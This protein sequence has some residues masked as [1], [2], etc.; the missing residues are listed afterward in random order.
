[1]K[2]RSPSFYVPYK[3]GIDEGSAE[4]C[5]GRCSENETIRFIKGYE[6]KRHYLL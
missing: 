5:K 3:H 4:D 1:M 6:Q 2:I